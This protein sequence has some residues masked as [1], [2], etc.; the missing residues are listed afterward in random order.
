MPSP[1]HDLTK[2]KLVE[3][4]NRIDCL[5]ATESAVGFVER[6][7]NQGFKEANSCLTQ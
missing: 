7:K 2:E 3:L 4:R 1:R 6:L 5:A